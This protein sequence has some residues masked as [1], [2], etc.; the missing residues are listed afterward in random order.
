MHTAGIFWVARS[1]WQP[2]A[3]TTATATAKARGANNHRT[4]GVTET[5]CSQV[6]ARVVGCI[7]GLS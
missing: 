3:N 2:E 6:V 1:G 4:T 5:A 7:F